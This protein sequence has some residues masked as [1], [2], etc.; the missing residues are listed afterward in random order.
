M[1]F[2]FEYNKVANESIILIKERNSDN[3]YFGYHINREFVSSYYEEIMNHFYYLESLPD[4]INKSFNCNY[5]F[6][7][8]Q[9]YLDPFFNVELFINSMGEVNVSIFINKEVDINSIWNREWFNRISLKNY[10]EENKEFLLKK[11]YVNVNELD[12]L[13]KNILKGK[14]DYQHMKLTRNIMR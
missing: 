8:D 7:K 2:T 3:L 13:L 5:A 11:L 10:I 6:F 14:L 4:I 12:E 9:I 1:N